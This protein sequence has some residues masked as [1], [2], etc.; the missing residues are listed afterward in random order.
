MYRIY[1]TD[2]FKEIY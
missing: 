2:T 1:A